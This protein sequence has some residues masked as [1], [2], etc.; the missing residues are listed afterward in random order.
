ME[1]A[2]AIYQPA[3]R[4]AALVL[5]GVTLTC[6]TYLVMRIRAVEIVK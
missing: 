6:L 2:G 3:L 4:D 1:P 5:G